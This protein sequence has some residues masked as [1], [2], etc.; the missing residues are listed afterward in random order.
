MKYVSVDPHRR[1][2]GAATGPPGQH[3]KQYGTSIIA[4]G[5]SPHIVQ[6]RGAKLTPEALYV[7]SPAAAAP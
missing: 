4:I 3:T 7:V 6:R 5:R 1:H 2:G